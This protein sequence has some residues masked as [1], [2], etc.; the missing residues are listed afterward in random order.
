MKKPKDRIT[1][2]EKE[3][4][5]YQ[6]YQMVLNGFPRY[7]I[8]VYGK[9][10]WNACERTIDGYI[11]DVADM[12]KSWNIKNHEYN[13]NLM[14]S[15]IED[16]I[17]RCYID[18]DK[19]TMVQLLKLQSDVL[20]LNEQRLQIEGNLNHNISVIKLNGPIEDGTAN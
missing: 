17:N 1:L 4:R 7:K 5:L 9:N 11:S 14:N 8:I 10:T 12:M 6:I 16:L 2:A 15:R 13:L 3:L 18:N 20:G 19:K